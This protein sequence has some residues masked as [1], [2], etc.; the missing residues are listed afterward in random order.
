[1]SNKNNIAIPEQEL[2][3]KLDVEL[4]KE[5]INDTSSK[6][7]IDNGN[8]VDKVTK[9]VFKMLK[10]SNLLGWCIGLVF[11][12]YLFEFWWGTNGISEVGKSSI[13][14]LKIL[15]FSLS[16]YLFGTQKE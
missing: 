7:P 9:D 12:I 1:M 5:V 10:A 6:F 14:I 15:I 16:G 2:D 8:Q 4:R 13:E 11:V 3:E